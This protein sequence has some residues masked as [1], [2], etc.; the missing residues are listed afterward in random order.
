MSDKKKDDVAE[1]TEDPKVDIQDK[2]DPV[3]PESAEQKPEEQ[4]GDADVQ[5]SQTDEAPAK[6]EE[7]AVADAASE[8][9][10]VEDKVEDQVAPE[11]GLLTQL[12]D[13]DADPLSEEEQDKLYDALWAEAE[14]GFADG[15]FTLELLGMD[16]LED[17]KLSS[18]KRKKLPNTIRLL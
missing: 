1:A 17:A 15:E 12:L 13:S 5:D 9:E 7:E 8:E 6:T 10:K 16:K 18:E 11:M 4:G 14:A 2:K 3:T